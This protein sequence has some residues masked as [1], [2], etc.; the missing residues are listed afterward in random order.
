[1][2]RPRAPAGQVQ[3]GC[4]EGAAAVV[5]QQQLAA[6]AAD[7]GPVHRYELVGLLWCGRCGRV[8]NPCWSHGRAAYRCRH[9]YTSARPQRERPR[10]LY[11]R[12]DFVTVAQRDRIDS[13]VA[14]RRDDRVD[15]ERCSATGDCPPALVLTY[16]WRFARSALGRWLSAVRRRCAPPSRPP[17]EPRPPERRRGRA[18]AGAS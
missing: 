8:L 17:D 16:A 15:D 7:G 3:C 5:G 10:N 13:E 12:E 11:V 1:M 9:G 2:R 18:P 4:R 6:A 14:Q